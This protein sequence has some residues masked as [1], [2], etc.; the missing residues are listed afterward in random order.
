[1]GY[2]YGTKT[3]FLRKDI[4]RDNPY[5][6]R[7]MEV[8]LFNSEKYWAEANETKYSPT[9]NAAHKSRARFVSIKKLKKAIAWSSILC[10]LTT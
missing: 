8:A 7:I 6:K 3:K 1:M 2:K 5:D 10:T 9:R 4:V